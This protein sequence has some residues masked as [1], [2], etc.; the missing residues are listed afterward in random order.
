MRL[1][2]QERGANVRRNLRR[3]RKPLVAMMGAWALLTVAVIIGAVFYAHANGF[4]P[5]RV[6]SLA[7]GCGGILGF[8]LIVAWLIVLVKADRKQSD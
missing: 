4:S 1:T 6:K 3:W 2:N 7:E 5:R 8:I